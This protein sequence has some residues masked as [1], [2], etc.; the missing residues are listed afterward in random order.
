MLKGKEIVFRGAGQWPGAGWNA[1]TYQKLASIGFNSERLYIKASTSTLEDP[2]GNITPS[3]ST[4][5]NQIELARQNNMNIILNVHFTPGSTSIS[6]RAFFTHPDYQERLTNFW[7]A[8]A[9]R[10]KDEPT[11][12]GFDLI[13]EPTVRLDPGATSNYDCNGTK[14]LSY[15]DHYSDIIQSIVDAIREVDRN[16]IIF[17]ERLWIDPGSDCNNCWWFG[18]NDQRDCWTNYDGNYNFPKIFDP[19]GNYAYTYHCYEPNTYCHQT[20]E[21]RTSMYPSSKIARYNEGPNGVPPWKY[22]K[23]YLDYAYTI[24]MAYIREVK[25]VPIYIGELGIT[26]GNYQY[27]GT[28]YVQDLY[29]I[30][31][32]RYKL[33]SSFHPYNIGE[34]H[35]N[36]N[37]DHEHAFRLAFGTN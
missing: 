20:L 35:P 12:V 25:N 30:L 33:S 8:I 37:P 26:E 31:L 4:L 10:Y 6:D 36:M 28:Q 9:E 5:D 15:F 27:G 11:I 22:C 19:A 17:A 14:Y 1:N 7:R 16:H 23:E 3:I 34:F 24:P 29:D 18:I 32:N 2:L 13:N 21:G